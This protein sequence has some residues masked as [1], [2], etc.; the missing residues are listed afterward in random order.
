LIR[1]KISLFLLIFFCSVSLS[2][3]TLWYVDNAAVGSNNGTSWT[4]AWESF[5]AIVWGGAGVV[6]GDTVYISG[7]SETKTYS[8][9]LVIGASGSAG[10]V[11][12]IQVGQD[13]GH[14]GVA[15]LDGTSVGNY[16][17]ISISNK[18]YIKISGQVGSGSGQN[19]KI[20]N[21]YYSGIN[22]ADVQHLEVAYTEIYYNG[23]TGTSVAYG[24]YGV[25]HTVDFFGNIHHCKIHYN[26]T[27]QIQILNAAASGPYTA[28]GYDQ[29][30][31]HDNDIYD[32]LAD[33][34][35]LPIGGASIY[36]NTIHGQ[37]PTG[38]GGTEYWDGI[39]IYNNY[40]RIYNNTFYDQQ[41]SDTNHGNGT[42]RWSNHSSVG[43]ITDIG[44]VQIYNNLVYELASP[45]TAGTYFRGV[46]I[47]AKDAGI[48]SV[49]DVL[50]ANNTFYG[51]AS[52][53]I[54]I[55]FHA[56]IG[57]AMVENIVVENNITADCAKILKSAL[58][59]GTGDL[60]I[61]YGSHGS[62]ADVIID[63]NIIYASSAASSTNCS[64]NST[65]YA[66][67]NFATACNCQGAGVSTNPALTASPEYALQATSTNAIDKGRD[68]SA[69]ISATDIIG[70]A[71]STWDIGAYEYD[72]AEDVTAPTITSVVINA[73]GTGL[74]LT[75][76]EPITVADSSG[77]TLNMS[78]GAAGL[79]FK[80]ATSN[81]M[82]FDITGRAIDVAETGTLDY[83]TVA[84]G[85]QDAA[86]NDLA[87]TGE[88]DEE[89][90]NNSEH[91]PSEVT[92]TITVQNSGNATLS[93]LA[94]QVVV[95]GEDSP[96]FTCTPLNG[97]RCVWSGTCG[98]TGNATTYKK[99]AIGE[100]C[101]VTLTAESIKLLN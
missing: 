79:S 59:I 32:S 8:E 14:N 7:G 36:N 81:T 85:I 82:N 101:T 23:F 55:G 69:S 6:A 63:N 12:T 34:I 74:T 17:G 53:G 70:L 100:D 40:Y 94:D 58:T 67:A 92:Y 38:T 61:T 5:A 54:Y 52:F 19:I 98:A 80:S 37:R 15:I 39:H 10:N 78:G 50:I 64:I 46:E 24:I 56:S 73:A 90:T 75:S 27:Q 29:L 51:L 65:S 88:T 41:R 72:G 66:F 43:K 77:F 4:N 31:I 93:P 2:H 97:W 16:A 30:L 22:L 3:A 21:W 89:V 96:T 76:S 26:Y 62:G 1:L 13:A 60:T 47:S 18:S 45:D 86:G 25:I 71:R 87:S 83:V 49:H 57:T 48:T 84:N 28:T 91:T 44:H 99:T 42:I 11:I 9:R 20:Q 33:G 68:L 95:T 35:Q